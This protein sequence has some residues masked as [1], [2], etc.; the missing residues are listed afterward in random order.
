MRDKCTF[1]WEQDV[2][3]QLSLSK[4]L[5]RKV[6]V[7]VD[8]D[9]S[10]PIVDETD[11]GPPDSR[12][13]GV[14]TATRMSDGSRNSLLA[15]SHRYSCLISCPYFVRTIAR[16]PLICCADRG[17]GACCFSV[18]PLLLPSPFAIIRRGCPTATGGEV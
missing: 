9:D 13:E 14:A 11:D 16:L 2:V 3:V 5:G 12:A 7:G 8:G 15:A 1:V 6:A 18:S 17:A 10:S 4:V